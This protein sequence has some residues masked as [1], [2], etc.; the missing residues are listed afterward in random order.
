MSVRERSRRLI[1]GVWQ[2]VTAEENGAGNGG[3]QPGAVR[4]VGPYTRIEMR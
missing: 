1:D 2:Y 3:S 4:M